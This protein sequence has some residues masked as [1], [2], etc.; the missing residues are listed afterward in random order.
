MSFCHFLDRLQINY[1]LLDPCF[2]F[3]AGFFG[4][5]VCAR[6]WRVISP[7]LIYSVIFPLLISKILIHF[8]VSGRNAP[9]CF[10]V[11][12]IGMRGTS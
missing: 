4:L 7:M 2:L 9:W 5:G 3:L 11:G 8:S 10:H 6:V 1:P 12:E